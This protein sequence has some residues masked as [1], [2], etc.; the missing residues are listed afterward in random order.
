MIACLIIVNEL[1]TSFSSLCLRP[2]LKRNFIRLR[3]GPESL[4]VRHT[5]Y[6]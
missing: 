6:A 2:V 4:H 3:T 5:I 1:K